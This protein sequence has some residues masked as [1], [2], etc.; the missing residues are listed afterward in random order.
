[1]ISIKQ[2]IF[3]A[4]DAIPSLEVLGIF[5]KLLKAFDRVWH[6][7]LLYRYKTNVIDYSL[8]YYLIKSFLHNRLQIVAFGGQTSNWKFLSGGVPQGWVLGPLFFL[9]YMNDLLERLKSDGKPLLTTF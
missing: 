2:N 7:D 6:E 4:F 9:V 8:Y 3:K 1:M 5:L